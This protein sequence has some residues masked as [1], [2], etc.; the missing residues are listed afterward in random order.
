MAII[1]VDPTGDVFDASVTTG[2]LGGEYLGWTGFPGWQVQAEHFGI[3]HIR[4]PAG[5]NAEDRIEA[6]G[7]AFDI[8]TP[9]LV[10]NWPK[11]NGSPREGLAEM[12]AY[13]ND[14]DASFA[15]IVPTARYVEMMQTDPDSARAWIASDVAAFT[16]RLFAGDFGPIP[17]DF[18]L[19]IGAEYYSTDAWA[20][21]ADTPDADALFAAVFA[22]L[23]TA[24]RDAETASGDDIYSIAVQAAR[25]QSNDDTPTT[26]DGELADADAFL[27]A[28]AAHGVEDAID[29]IVWHRYVY[30]FD[31][32]AHHLTADQGEHTLTDHLALW[33][34][35]LGHP[36]D[37]VLGWAAPDIDSNGA[38][39]TDPNFDFGPRAAHATLQMF[40]E[41]AEAGTDYAT[42][43]GIDSPWTG[44]ISTGTTSADV[45]SVLFNGEV[46][47]MMTESL[48]GLR[49]TDAFQQNFVPVG[50]DNAVVETD[51]VNVFGFTN[52]A[53]HAVT[54]AAAWDLTENSTVTIAA[55][56]VAAAFVS[57][58][59]LT[60]D[61]TDADAGGR[62]T[63]PYASADATGAVT[64]EGVGDFD[65]L[66][67]THATDA[68]VSDQHTLLD[69]TTGR[70]VIRLSGDDDAF[71]FADHSDRALDAG[72]GDD[73]VLGSALADI[74]AGGAGDDSIDG[75]AGN[76]LIF[77]DDVDPQTFLD[78]L[79]GGEFDFA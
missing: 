11:S 40:S 50:S 75:G 76:D 52:G 67:V 14:T 28:Y 8:A 63:A 43:Y 23:V 41:L 4:W 70:G 29:A 78:W 10:D 48:A 20:A 9:T 35:A 37:L 33:E 22:E 31:Q 66:R 34:T 74:I 32:T 71:T 62:F 60:P 53:D 7:Y 36:L 16:T 5:I 38:F 15:M 77:G 51:H 1:S 24:F 61:G 69:T 44:A 45:F 3:H 64:I 46:Y 54:F 13:A 2:A 30:T 56:D 59:H 47:A 18:V 65:V 68:D 26:Q 17:P 73:D 19:E 58:T 55:P 57:V 12:F 21:L 39:P 27:A 72:A 25:F 42:L 79:Q 49:P 6:A